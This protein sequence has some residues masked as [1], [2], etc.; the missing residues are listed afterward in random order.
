MNDKILETKKDYKKIFQTQII[1]E[2]EC[3]NY[4]F[5]P[6]LTWYVNHLLL[7]NFENYIPQTLENIIH[8]KDPQNINDCKIYLKNIGE[9]VY[10][11]LDKLIYD[12]NES[13]IL[14]EGFELEIQK[15]INK[16]I[17]DI[18]E[19]F[20][21]M[22]DKYQDSKNLIVLK[23]TVHRVIIEGVFDK[24]FEFYKKSNQRQDLHIS[25]LLY[26][27]R[28]MDMNDLDIPKTFHSDQSSSVKKISGISNTKDLF[29]MMKSIKETSDLILENLNENKNMFDTKK[30]QHLT[31]DELI[32]IYT[33][34]IIQAQL[35][36]TI[37]FLKFLSDYPIPEMNSSEYQYSLITFEAVLENIKKEAEKK[38]LGE[39]TPLPQDLQEKQR[40]VMTQKKEDY[41]EL[42]KIEKKEQKEEKDHVMISKS[43]SLRKDKQGGDIGRLKDFLESSDS[44]DFSD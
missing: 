5:K 8:E 19:D 41:I 39:K 35:K 15:K 31:N 17:Q 40:N 1:K 14:L 9:G 38:G 37:T 22:N 6:Y 23:R 33:F 26:Y 36:N 4:E 7:D 44:D 25:K 12:F 27:L 42:P 16:Y 30:I 43:I 13:Y 32:P 18:T 2:E 3:Y 34:C 11:S 20:T 10:K 28:D 24:L 21:L 29:E